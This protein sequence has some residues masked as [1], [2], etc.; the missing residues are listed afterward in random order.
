MGDSFSNRS[1][2]WQRNPALLAFAQAEGSRR[3]EAVV[4][5]VEIDNDK[6]YCAKSS[7]KP[8]TVD[9]T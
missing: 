9:I 6:R 1:I 8:I 2:I 4:L 3:E 7:F 5:D